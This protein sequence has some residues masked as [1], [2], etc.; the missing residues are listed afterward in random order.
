MEDQPMINQSF[1]MPARETKEITLSLE[2][3]ERFFKSILNDQAYEETLSLF[4]GKLR[5]RLRA[6][7][8]QEN[9]DVVNQ[10][11]ADKK[12]GVAAEN[13]AYFI[14]IST[15]RLALSLV[16]IDDV[17]YSSVTKENFSPDTEND[18]YVLSRAK[19]MLA[20]H[21]P[22]LAMF[23]DAFSKFEARL[24]KLTSE[25]QTQNFWKASA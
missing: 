16:S 24:L 2:E 6:M 7:T 14:T 9:T 15:Y 18:S 19:I 1:D 4:D 20:W 11:V 12:N 25:V 5:I 22:K 3:K 17:P 10:I 23:L 21:T 13:D 8:V